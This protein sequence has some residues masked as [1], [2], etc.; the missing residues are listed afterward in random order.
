MNLH[1]EKETILEIVTSAYKEL[2]IESGVKEIQETWDSMKFSVQR[3]MKGK[4]ERGYILGSVDDVLQILDDNVMNLQRYALTWG[5][6]QI[7]NK[8]FRI[9]RLYATLTFASPSVCSFVGLLDHH[10]Y[11]FSTSLVSLLLPMCVNGLYHRPCPPL[12][13]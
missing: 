6:F 3:Y 10:N 1:K 12:R 8:S 5:K 2:T 13:N 4:K 7:M 9:G 11:Q